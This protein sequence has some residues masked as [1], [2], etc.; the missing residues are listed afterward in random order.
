MISSYLFHNVKNS[1][2]FPHSCQTLPGDT[3][4]LHGE[5]STHQLLA[6]QASNTYYNAHGVTMD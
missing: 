2:S 3:I 5:D 1:S 4:P 6:P